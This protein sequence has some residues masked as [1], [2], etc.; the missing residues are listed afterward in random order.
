M[1]GR[2]GNGRARKGESRQG[3]GGKREM[4]GEGGKGRNGNGPDP[5]REEIYSQ[6]NDVINNI[7]RFLRTYYCAFGKLHFTR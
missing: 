6:S 2:I 7:N 3:K 1:D 5:V 4:G